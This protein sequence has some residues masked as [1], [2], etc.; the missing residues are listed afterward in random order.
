[1]APGVEALAVR[2]NRSITGVDKGNSI[3]GVKTGTK[4]KLIHW[5]IDLARRSE[6]FQADDEGSIPFTRSN[7]FNDLSMVVT[8]F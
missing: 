7:V 8:P 4:R 3:K 6:A 2:R 1:M 5:R